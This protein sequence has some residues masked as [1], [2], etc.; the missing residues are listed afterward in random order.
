MS[1][2]GPN[3]QVIYAFLAQLPTRD[4]ERF[5]NWEQNWSRASPFDVA[6]DSSVDLTPIH[7]RLAPTYGSSTRSASTRSASTVSTAQDSMWS[8]RSGRSGRSGKSHNTTL[9][10]P[11]RSTASTAPSVF[12]D[13]ATIDPP[14]NPRYRL[15][16]EYARLGLCNETFGPEETDFWEWHVGTLHLQDR[17][18][19]HCICW[20]CDQEF[21]A[22]DHNG[23]ERENFRF[24]LEHIRDHIIQGRLNAQD[25]RPDYFLLEHMYRNGLLEK[26]HYQ[27]ECSYTEGPTASG[28]VEYNYTP[29]ER[30]RAKELESRVYHD[31]DKEERRRRRRQG[32]GQQRPAPR[33][34]PP[35]AGHM[36]ARQGLA[37]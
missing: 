27:L 17:L 21:S 6:S 22:T 14:H 20:F 2:T 34:L 11:P 10:S 15:P 12:N 19:P 29:P 9:S 36:G 18:P 37:V 26:V 28:I 4:D 1:S 5:H 7:F 32:Q 35:G 16:C 13:H 31:N 3:S 25:M 23:D 8:R 24:R 30:R 33:V